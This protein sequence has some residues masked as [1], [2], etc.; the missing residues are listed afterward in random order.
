[1]WK[2]KVITLWFRALGRLHETDRPLRD[3]LLLQLVGAAVCVVLYGGLKGNI[4]DAQMLRGAWL[5]SMQGGVPLAMVVL[6][7]LWRE[8]QAGRRDLLAHCSAI[9]GTIAVSVLMAARFT[10]HGSIKLLKLYEAPMAAVALGGIGLLYAAAHRSRMRLDDFG[11]GLGDWRWWLPRSA[12]ATGVLGVGACAAL[13]TFADLAAFY[14]RVV[15]ARHDFGLLME[16]QLGMFMAIFGWEMLFRG[17]LLWV[18]ARR[19]DIKGAIEANAVIFFLGHLNKPPSEMFLSLP[20]GIVACW[21]GWRA[22]SFLPVWILHSVQL[23]VMNL[24][25]Y[26]M[27]Q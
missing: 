20:G 6:W 10:G 1:M 7:W 14:P 17:I 24:A 22:G 11:L 9:L 27:R 21:F 8:H 26:W 13:Y 5:C 4:L 16:S 19:G 23:F 3:D 25:G 12:I 15:D 2:Q 18:F